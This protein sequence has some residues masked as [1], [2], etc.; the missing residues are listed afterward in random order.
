MKALTISALLAA[1]PFIRAQQSVSSFLV[2]LQLLL[3][4]VVCVCNVGVAAMYVFFN[5]PFFNHAKGTLSIGGG[6]GWSKGISRLKGY[7][8]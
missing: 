5:I 3:T 4:G 1:L 7:C 2:N 6:I 8:F